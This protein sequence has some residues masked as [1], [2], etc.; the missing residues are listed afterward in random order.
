MKAGKIGHSLSRCVRSILDKE[1]DIDDVYVII[2]RTRITTRDKLRGVMEEYTWRGDATSLSGYDIEE[3][4]AVAYK[5]WDDGKLHQP[6][7]FDNGWQF[8]GL[9]KHVWFD[10]VPS[11]DFASPSVVEAYQQYDML[12]KLAGE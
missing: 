4:M 7:L 12:R 2:A 9:A 1:V 5:L 8:E 10:I 6:R 11:V 3:I